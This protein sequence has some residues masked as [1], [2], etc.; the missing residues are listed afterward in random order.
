MESWNHVGYLA[1]QKR[2]DHLG[3]EVRVIF[4]QEDLGAPVAAEY[5]L[6]KE[7]GAILGG[8]VLSGFGFKPLAE[9]FDS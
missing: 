9:V 4:W 7:E 8:N 2:Y 6:N 5:F 1:V 3:V